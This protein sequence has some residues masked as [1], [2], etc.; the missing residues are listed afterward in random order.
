L[1][2][3]AC[4]PVNSAFS[5]ESGSLCANSSRCCSWSRAVRTSPSGASSVFCT[6]SRA[7]SGTARVLSRCSAHVDSVDVQ[8]EHGSQ[9]RLGGCSRETQQQHQRA[10]LLAAGMCTIEPGLGDEADLHLVGAGTQAGQEEDDMK[11]GVLDR[12]LVKDPGVRTNRCTLARRC[13]S[14]MAPFTRRC[15]GSPLGDIH[16]DVAGLCQPLV[17][18]LPKRTAAEAIG[19]RTARPRAR[20]AARTGRPSSST[21]FSTMASAAAREIGMAG[22]GVTDEL[23][24]LR[25]EPPR[26]PKRK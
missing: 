7:L 23:K 26:A 12:E 5:A 21:R 19:Q 18:H 3:R 1:H 9:L 16:V 17:R 14:G 10:A 24:A 25:F 2:A 11:L 13:A 20:S 15:G 4:L 8:R 6:Y 22:S